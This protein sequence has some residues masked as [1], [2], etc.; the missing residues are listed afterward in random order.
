MPDPLKLFGTREEA[1]PVRHLRAGPLCVDLVAGNLRTV[2]FAGV[3]VLRAIG[4]VV[5]DRDWGTYDTPI[6]DLAIEEDDDRFRVHYRAEVEAP[7]GVRLCFVAS[8]EGSADGT[9]AFAVEA[10]TDGAFETNRCGF[11]VLHPIEGNAGAPVRVEHTDGTVED[12]RFPDHIEPWQPFQDIRSLA[13]EP[14][15]GLRMT[16]RLEGDAFEMEDQR[17]WSDASY[18]TYVRPLAR[19]WPYRLE[20]GRPDRQSVTLRIAAQAGFAPDSADTARGPVAV[21]LGAPLPERMPRFGLAVAP[22]DT[23]AVLAQPVRLQDLAPA[24]LLFHFD[25]LAGHGADALEGFS[26]IAALAPEAECALELVLPGQD[27]P[28]AETAQ[29]ARLIEASPFR[30][31]TIVVG[32]SVDRQST[33][34]GSQW[35]ACPPLEDVYRAARAAFPGVTLGGGMFSY[36]TELN[37]KRVPLG[38]L[39]FVTHATNPIVHAAD[40]LSVMQTLEAIPFIARSTRAFVGNMPY[41]LGPTTIGMR[42]NPYG[43]RTMPNPEGKRIPMA[44]DDPRAR[45]LF[46]AAFLVGYAARLVGVGVEAW[47]GASLAGPR[48][49]LLPGGGVAPAFHVARGLA[50][51]GGTGRLDLQSTTP[52]AVDGIAARRPDGGLEIW[53]ANLT[54]EP[55]DVAIEG[56]GPDA[57]VSLLDEEAFDAAAD[58][59]LPAARASDGRLVLPPYAVL[60]LLAPQAP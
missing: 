50:A 38:D 3:E 4:Y 36:F 30:P 29:A 28:A 19:P 10:V 54:P 39:D 2:R 14:V 17:A 48:G 55:Q 44:N 49:L 53:L 57:A 40:D 34:P 22:E 21:R 18:K 23:Q 32:P 1:A 41:R 60:R 43:S 33:P 59:A 7:D 46:G 25:P 5:R 56:I 11:C 9:L 31:H 24:F 26:H 16:C 35:P 52:G 8:I 13:H 27:D 6:R 47:A 42:Q 37:R 15:P 45:G 58:G 51:L 12:A 20:A